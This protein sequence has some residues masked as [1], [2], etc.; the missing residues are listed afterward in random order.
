MAG[1]TKRAGGDMGCSLSTRTDSVMALDA[2][3]TDAGVIE[4]RTKPGGRHVA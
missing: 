4:T 1:F 3:S 2:I